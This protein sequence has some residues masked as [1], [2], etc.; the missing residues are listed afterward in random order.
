[1]PEGVTKNVKLGFFVLAGLSALILTLYLI[2]KSQNV[3]GSNVVLKARFKNVSGLMNGSNILFSGIH[4]GTVS[5]IRIIDDTTIEVKFLVEKQMLPYIHQ[6]ARVS[7]GSEGLMGNKLINI[8]PVNQPSPPVIENDILAASQAPGT[9]EMLQTLN[10]TNTNIAEISEDLKSSAHRLKDSKALWGILDDPA[11][12][13]NMHRST[14]NI[15]KASANVNAV[16]QDLRTMIADVRNGKGSVGQLLVDTAFA[17]SLNQTLV[18][19]KTVGEKAAGLEDELN[20]TV[21]D[22]RYDMDHGSGSVH[23]L[24]K[25]SSLA[26]KLNAT[27]DNV[28]KGTESFSQDMEALKHNFLLRGY[29]RKQE[30]EKKKNNLPPA[31]P[32]ANN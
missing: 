3:F 29:F 18:K 22:I 10:R 31:P 9:D 13:L 5:K 8:L 16:T 15:S 19:I 6:N 12:A 26:N 23:T 4:V 21:G 20:R 27:M 11:L 2:G 7:I 17:L 14:D 28:Q 1:M 32:V 25:D 30:K 24:L